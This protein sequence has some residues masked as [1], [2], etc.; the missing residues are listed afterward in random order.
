MNRYLFRFVNVCSR[1]EIFILYLQEK[2][3]DS[4]LNVVEHH[5]NVEHCRAGRAGLTTR[6]HGMPMSAQIS[7]HWLV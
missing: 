1:I 4:L 5:I 6:H 2:K 3:K 7:T